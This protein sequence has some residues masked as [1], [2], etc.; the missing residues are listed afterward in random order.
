MIWGL[1]ILA[2]IWVATF[3]VL[4]GIYLS[5]RKADGQEF[6]YRFPKE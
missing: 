4:R 6:P 2:A 3:F 5:A 1:L